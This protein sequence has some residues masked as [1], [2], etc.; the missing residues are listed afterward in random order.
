MGRKMITFV[1]DG[2]NGITAYPSKQEAADAGDGSLF[3]SLDQLDQ[4]TAGCTA[5]R[6]V[7]IWNGIPG[8]I[9][10]TKFTSRQIAL[11]RIWK[12]VQVLA[13]A[14]A[15][16]TA[17][18]VPDVAPEPA[19]PS[20]NATSPTKTRTKATKAAPEPRGESKKDQVIAMVRQPG[21]ASLKS[22]MEATGWQPHTVRGFMATVPKKLEIEVVSA[23]VDGERTYSA[24]KAKVTGD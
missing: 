22:I 1:I 16:E 15:P 2:E 10:V 8:V 4:A 23:K 7:E 24:A 6:L 9:E 3:S 17:Q 21:G 20:R 18:D 5:S 13:A 19:K 11:G 14:V 12:A